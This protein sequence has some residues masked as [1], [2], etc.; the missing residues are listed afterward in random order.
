MK[1]YWTKTIFFTLIIIEGT[2][3]LRIR[4]ESKEAK[5]DELKTK[6][7][8]VDRDMKRATSKS[9]LSQLE[10]IKK[11]LIK[12]TRIWRNNLLTMNELK[13]FKSL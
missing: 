5:N 9:K 12:N 8:T 2:K 1:K 6:L 7:E 11:P 4:K 3:A 10:R 13:L